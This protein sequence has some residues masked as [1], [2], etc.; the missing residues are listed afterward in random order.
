ML[1]ILIHIIISLLTCEPGQDLYARFGHTALRVEDTERRMDVVFNYGLFNFNQPN[2]YTNF[3][4]GKTYYQIG[5]QDT[6]EFMAEYAAEGRRVHSQVLDLSDEQATWICDSLMRNMRPEN[7]EYLYNFVYDNCAT[8]P[9]Y[10]IRPEAKQTPTA[11]DAPSYRQ[12]IERHVGAYHYA[13]FGINLLLGARADEPADTLWLP[14][15]VMNYMATDSLVVRQSTAA[16]PA[17]VVHWYEDV[18]LYLCLLL[19][20]LLLLTR[21]D[22]RRH[23]LTWGVD[24]AL[25]ILYLLVLMLVGYLTFFSLHPLVG[26]G[27]RLLIIPT[28]HLCSRL[29]YFIPLRF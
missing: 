9:L 2:F 3:L 16:F 28:I 26:F 11:A 15:C 7:R 27:P 8:R 23:R 19:V 25:G 6:R 22:I 18:R 17:P 13:M 24:L 29:L 1:T 12:L 5:A 4:K 20:A 21:H 10:L 14:E